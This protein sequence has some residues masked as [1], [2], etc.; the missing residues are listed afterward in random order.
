MRSL[1]A[2][3]SCALSRL[4]FVL[5]LA[6]AG[7]AG[8]Q[9]HGA[10]LYTGGNG[11]FSSPSPVFGFAIN[12]S[13]GT[14]S[15]VSGS[16]FGLP[17][18][19]LAIAGHP[20][21]KFVYVA[22]NDG[23][24]SAFTVDSLG[25]MLTPAPGSPYTIGVTASGVYPVGTLLS[26]DP[27]GKYLYAAAGSL[28]YGFAIDS[29]SG[30]L[31]A[32]S[33]SPFAATSAS[34]VTVDPSGHYLVA[35]SGTEAWVYAIDSTTGAL[36]AIGSGVN[37]C[38]GTRMTFEPSGHFL[39]GTAAGIAA[40]SFSSSSGG[41]TPL[42]GSPF[43]SGTGFSGLAAHPSGSFLYAS[44]LNCVNGGPSTWLYGYV[45]DPSSGALTPIGGSPFALP[46]PELGDCYY[47]ED[48]A[49]ETS[50]NFVYTV[51]AN[52]GTATYSVNHSTGALTP[53]SNAFAGTEAFTL[54]TIPNAIS[55]TATLT[56]LQ[57]VPG[58]AQIAGSTLGKPYQF[59]LKGAFSDGSTGFLTGSAA[60]SSS[61]TGVATIASGLATS[62]GNG[63]TT[64]TATVNGISSTATLTVTATALNSISVTPQSTT[65][66]DGT[67]IQ[68]KATG[69][70]SDGSTVDLTN[71]VT[72]TSSNAATATVSAQGLVQ[73]VTIGNATI[74][75][76][77]TVT[78]T[79]TVTVVPPFT[80][81]A[82]GSN[83]TSASVSSGGSANFGLSLTPGANF[84]GS[85]TLT[86]AN[87]P[88]NATCSLNPASATLT[89][90]SPA[91]VSVT[92]ATGQ[93]LSSQTQ[94][95]PVE[96]YL[97]LAI[98]P[99]L[100]LLF[101]IRRMR[102]RPY[103]LAGIL[104]VVAIACTSCGSGNKATNSGSGGSGNGA[105]TANS[106]PPGTY[107]VVVTATSAQ[108]ATQNISLT[109]QVQ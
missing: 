52:Y 16:P 4:L 59:T 33:G 39:Y 19:F 3:R 47:D 58:T 40:C 107:N 12:P 5:C 14:Q 98:L 29:S 64:I 45:I 95:R 106:T 82:T 31:T 9:T 43:V 41:L 85:V 89:G 1:F 28:L 62:T 92:I 27:A 48:V 73:S 51:D 2:L 8:A 101:P 15:E 65:V 91:N 100:A 24:L 10:F 76:T 11:S 6:G 42:S 109:V 35:S 21:G 22:S 53:V 7:Y 63:A 102:F 37:G 70:Y 50:G 36:T 96:R 26:I 84:T 49:V 56:G 23:S 38:G 46:S 77:S 20:S 32:I 55:S 103:T 13:T 44:D 78:G 74:S 25:G 67:A 17:G 81:A 104:F 69:L 66:Y 80:W 54:A 94:P 79:T 86:C 88:S 68:L 108:H 99:A 34:A 60:W 61:N 83:G 72:W 18:R 105:S 97:A 93:T 30:A 71:S 90:G 87:L 57:I 75:A